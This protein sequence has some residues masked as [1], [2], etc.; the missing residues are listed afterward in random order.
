MERLLCDF[1]FQLG[2]YPGMKNVRIWVVFNSLV[3][4][5]RAHK[6]YRNAGIGGFFEVR[7]HQH[8]EHHLPACSMIFECASDRTNHSNNGTEHE[9]HGALKQNSPREMKNV[10]G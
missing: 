8:L 5:V 1:L 3:K 7:N 4:V 6:A 9:V 2:K 10:G